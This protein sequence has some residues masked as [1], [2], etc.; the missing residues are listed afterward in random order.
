MHCWAPDGTLVG[1][2]VTV[3]TTANFCFAK[4]G[5]WMCAEDKLFLCQLKAKG[6]LV[7]TE[8]E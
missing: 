8:C 2:I 4:E 7:K 6:C 3:G 1:K 5:I